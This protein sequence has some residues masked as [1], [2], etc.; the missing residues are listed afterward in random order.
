[1]AGTCWRQQYVHVVW[2]CTCSVNSIPDRPKFTCHGI[3]DAIPTISCDAYAAV[4]SNSKRDKANHVVAGI[5]DL[6][7]A[8]GLGANWQ[9]EILFSIGA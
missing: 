9:F 5:V 6:R 4:R 2:H 8:Q 3:S 7:Q 1:M